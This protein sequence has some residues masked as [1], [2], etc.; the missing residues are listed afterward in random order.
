[1]ELELEFLKMSNYLLIF[2]HFPFK[3]LIFF[4]E[5]TF[6]LSH[7]LVSNECLIFLVHLF[8]NIGAITGAMRPP[9]SRS[10]SVVL[11]HR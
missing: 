1:M 5:L 3:L 4:V 10:N 9:W 8:S 6:G 7:L 11:A 2:E